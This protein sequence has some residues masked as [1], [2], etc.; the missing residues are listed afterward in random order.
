ML[1][2]ST[3]QNEHRLEG[4]QN[5]LT[6]GG[7]GTD[8]LI[9]ESRSQKILSTFDGTRNKHVNVWFKLWKVKKPKIVA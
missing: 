9:L 8:I 4:K 1:L 6:K 3:I 2:A 7:K 5:S